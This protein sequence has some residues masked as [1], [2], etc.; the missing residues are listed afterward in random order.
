MA[1]YGNTFVDEKYSAILEPNLFADNTM[2]PNVTY[3]AQ[4]QGDAGAGVVKIYKSTV[5]GASDPTTPAGDFT[6]QK[7]YF[8]DEKNLKM[9]EIPG[10]YYVSADGHEVKDFIDNYDENSELFSLI[11]LFSEK[12]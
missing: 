2:L 4:Y 8:W 7:H 10:V 6:E 3:N 9:V 12:K 5:D 1:K 11:I